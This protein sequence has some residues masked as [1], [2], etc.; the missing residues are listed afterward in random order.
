MNKLLV[1]CVA[2]VGACGEHELTMSSDA[3]PLDMTLPRDDFSIVPV[4]P[5]P[6]ITP[7][8]LGQPCIRRSDCDPTPGPSGDVSYCLIDPRLPPVVLDVDAGTSVPAGTCIR[9]L[10]I[11]ATAAH[12]FVPYGCWVFHGVP[13]FFGPPDPYHPGECWSCLHFLPDH[14]LPP[15]TQV[16]SGG[17]TSLQ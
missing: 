6:L 14:V 8:P 13:D 11:E 10:Y 16:C 7:G 12:P 1:V 5:P 9:A 2:L 4:E 3:A 15:D 17:T